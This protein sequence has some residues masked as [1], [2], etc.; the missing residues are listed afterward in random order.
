MRLDLYGC[1]PL[2]LLPAARRLPLYGAAEGMFFGTSVAFPET[3]PS[4][5]SG[6]ANSYPQAEHLVVG[7]PGPVEG[8]PPSAFRYRNDLVDGVPAGVT[9]TPEAQ[10]VSS[11]RQLGDRLG[12]SVAASTYQ[13]GA[14]CLVASP[15]DPKADEDGGGYLYAD[16][17]PG[18]TWMDTPAL[19]V[20][21]PLRWGGLPPDWWKK[22]TPQIEK[23]LS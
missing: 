10:F 3:W 17:D 22:F 11:G 6:A 21:P 1:R 16:G 9:F 2:L 7:G 4:D 8:E 18:P 23:Y 15:G 14:W 5:G 20:A 19:I 12:I 13:H